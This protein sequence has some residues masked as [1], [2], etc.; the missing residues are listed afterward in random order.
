MTY[1]EFKDLILIRMDI[2][3]PDAK[4]I[5]I[6]KIIK[7]NDVKLDG[8][9]I[10]EKNCN[11]SPTIYLHQYYE[12]YCRGISFE[13]ILDDI[14]NVYEENK[15]D[16]DV[17]VSIFSNFD[18]A[19]SHIVYKLINREMNQELLKDVPFI[20]YLD[21]AIIFYYYFDNPKAEFSYGSVLIHNNHACLWGVDK[22]DLMKYAKINT[23]NIMGVT[24]ENMNNFIL[25]HERESF[26]GLD[27][28]D[29]IMPLYI[30]SNRSKINGAACILYDNLL[31]EISSDFNS[32]LVIIPSSVH[33]VLFF[34]TIE[35]DSYSNFNDLV[36]EV[37]ANELEPQDI[38]SDH[39]Y[40][41]SKSNNAISC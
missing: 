30:L 14:R 3:Y 6:K 12:R 10:Q 34:P 2:Y 18:K 23:P 9:V 1:N 21:L 15:V 36:K 27:S 35:L 22:N 13:I 8:L 38:L 29:A 37:N 33:E 7:N 31:A 25:E 28:I 19:K 24:I 11:V 5:C 16:K 4:S 17:D 41:Y 40:Y 39:L 20:P 26:E 32:D